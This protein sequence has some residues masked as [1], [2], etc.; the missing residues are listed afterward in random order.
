MTSS[1]KGRR[2]VI[3]VALV[4]LAV[5]QGCAVMTG[6]YVPDRASTTSHS[7]VS[8]FSVLHFSNGG[9]AASAALHMPRERE[10]GLFYLRY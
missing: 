1:N 10:T 8:R 4:G 3:A 7:M 5:L 2:L 9:S 6:P